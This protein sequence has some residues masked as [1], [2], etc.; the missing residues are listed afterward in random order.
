MSA[1]RDS[2]DG[3]VWLG[4]FRDEH[5]GDSQALS[6]LADAVADGDG[7][8]QPHTGECQTSEERAEATLLGDGSLE[9]GTERGDE[10]MTSD[11]PVRSLYQWA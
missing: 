5:A 9:L 1:D 8:R 4:D 10:W 7:V 3:F 11:R 6:T 2:R